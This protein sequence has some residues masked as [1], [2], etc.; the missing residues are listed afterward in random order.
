MN[1]SFSVAAMPE[2]LVR[3]AAGKWPDVHGFFVIKED[4]SPVPSCLSVRADPIG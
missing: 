2:P 4:P 1:A 3:T